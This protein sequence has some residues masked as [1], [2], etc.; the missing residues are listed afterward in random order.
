MKNIKKALSRLFAPRAW[1]ANSQTAGVHGNGAVSLEASAAITRGQIVG[2]DSGKIKP[3]TGDILPIG[4][5][6]DNAVAGEEIAVLLFGSTPGTLS[7]LSGG[8]IAAGSE[9]Y[10][11]ASGKVSATAPAASASK[12]CIGIAVGAAA[13]GDEVEI[14]HCVARK[15]TTPAS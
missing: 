12:Y 9:V 13:S 2:F 5:A 7:V 15:I 14:A 4:V 10:S 11:E 8:T 3:A 1:A 6:D